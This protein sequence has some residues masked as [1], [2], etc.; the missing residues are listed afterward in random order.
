MHLIVVAALVVAL[1][2]QYDRVARLEAELR[3][4][5]YPPIYKTSPKSLSAPQVQTK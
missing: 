4:R 2:V 3:A 5:M 1:M